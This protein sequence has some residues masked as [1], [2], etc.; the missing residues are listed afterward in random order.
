MRSVLPAALAKSRMVSTS[1]APGPVARFTV[2]PPAVSQSAV[3]SVPLRKLSLPP[4]LSRS[5]PPRPEKVSPPVPP[6]SV[7]RPPRR[8][9]ATIDR[10]PQ[11]QA[12]RR[13]LQDGC[14]AAGHVDR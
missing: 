10:M 9:H 6:T 8:D 11:G 12:G 2:T 13:A 7:S 4:P 1:P 3:S 14:L 5:A